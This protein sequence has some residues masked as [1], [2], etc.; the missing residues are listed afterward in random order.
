VVLIDVGSGTG[1]SS[2]LF[3]ARGLEVI[4]LEPNADMRAAAAATAV[5]ARVPRP[6]YREGTAEATGLPDEAADV[7]LA[8]QAFHWFE[9]D[10]ALAEFY[11]VLK[12]DGWLV[13]VW[14]ERNERDPFTAAYGTVI[15]TAPDA[16]VVE[17]PRGQAG[18]VLLT[19]PLF[20]DAER[21]VFANEQVLEEEELLGRAFSASYAPRD[22]STATAW[23]NSLRI[24]FSRHQ[25]EGKVVLRYETAVYLARR[26]KQKQGLACG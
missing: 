10:A 1:I 12:P 8:A 19:S 23:A 6:T 3:A 21:V 9:R 4:G 13:L 18:A 22:P 25:Q 11:R 24:V 15:R 7:V 16:S 5:D 26:R 17:V 20:R 14:N 2:R